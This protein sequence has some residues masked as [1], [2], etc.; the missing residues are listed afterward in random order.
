MKVMLADDERSIIKVVKHV[1]EDMGYDFV[2]AMNGK[3]AVDLFF[4]GKS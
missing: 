3:D 4:R 2:F 1:V